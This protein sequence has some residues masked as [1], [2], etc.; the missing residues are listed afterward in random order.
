MDTMLRTSHAVLEADVHIGLCLDESKGLKV[1]KFVKY[2]T[3]K[4]RSTIKDYTLESVD[5]WYGYDSVILRGKMGFIRLA[6]SPL[7]QEI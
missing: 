2:V 3:G 1:Y 7:F 6:L 4:N 5:N